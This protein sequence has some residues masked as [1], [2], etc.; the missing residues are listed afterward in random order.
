MWTRVIAILAVLL[1]A[2][3]AWS[4]YFDMTELPGRSGAKYIITSAV[5]TSDYIRIE[6]RGFMRIAF[7]KGSAFTATAFACETKE[8]AADTCTSVATLSA[9]NTKIDVTTGRQWLLFDVTAAETG[10]NTSY[11]TIQSNYQNAGMGGGGGGSSDIDGDGLYEVA[12]LWDADGD[13]STFT[14]CAGDATPDIACKADGEQIYRDAIDDIN[15]AVHGCGYGQMEVDGTIKLGTGVFLGWPCWTPTM[16]TNTPENHETNDDNHDVA[17]TDPAYTA[18]PVDGDGE[19]LTVLSFQDWQ[20]SLIGSGADTRLLERG[21]MSATLRRDIGTYFAND[22]GPWDASKN[23]NVWFSGGDNARMISTGFHN[24]V[25]DLN[26]PNGANATQHASS[27]GWWTVYVAVDFTTW[28]NDTQ[29][30]CM[31]TTAG[32]A[33]TD[34]K[35]VNTADDLRAGDVLILT[36]LPYTGGS[37]N[38]YEVVVRETPSVTC[39]GSNLGLFV[40]IGG[41]YLDRTSGSTKVFPPHSSSIAVGQRVLHARSGYDNTQVTIANMRLEPQDPWNEFGGRCTASGTAFKTLVTSTGTLLGSPAS[42]LTAT[43]DTNT[44]MSCDTLPFFGL[45]GGGQVMITDVVLANWHKFAIDAGGTGYANIQRVTALYGN[46][47]EISDSS[48]GWRFHDIFVD[49]S[50]FGS[51]VIAIFGTAPQIDTLTIR[52]SVFSNVI[53]LD[54][55]SEKAS[56]TNIRNEGNAFAHTILIMCG[57]KQSIV[58]DVY[59]TGRGGNS[60]GGQPATVYIN[61]DNTA[62]IVTQNT[63]ENI[64]SDGMDAAQLN[65]SAPVIVFNVSAASGNSADAQWAAIQGNRF[66]N[67]N[68]TGYVGGTAGESS[69]LFGVT[70]ADSDS[71]ADDDGESVIFTKNYFSASSVETNGRVFCMLNGGTAAINATAIDS[72]FLNATTGTPPWGDPNG[73]GNMDGAVLAPYQRCDAAELGNGTITVD[74]LSMLTTVSSAAISYT[75]NGVLTTDSVVWGFKTDVSGLDGY[76][77]TN[78]VIVR[79]YPTANTINF[80]AT[81]ATAVTVDP[82]SV[83]IW[84]KAVR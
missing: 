58:R 22:M 32:V 8:Y 83:E 28:V 78:S 47:G 12:Y 21:S 26:H 57:T 14:T 31:R 75:L 5:T 38:T 16:T 56:I 2:G 84:W 68:A 39:G 11:I 59:Q 49:Q 24:N 72:D 82:A 25:T 7:T 45:W 33:G 23:N 40:N 27:K 44:D 65:D 17:V 73:C 51:S 46:G 42:F 30:I 69:C 13:G 41:S 54:A 71:P 76:S 4:A 70:E 61:C 29:M 19:T 15:C 74:F 63:F 48:N 77:G 55:Q 80:K 10:S 18:C 81:N 52:N 53:Q 62:N 6:S 79:G 1:V 37:Y 50:Y 64:T 66:A 43:D 20:G 60:M 3:P 9:T 34:Y 67:V 35:T 36:A